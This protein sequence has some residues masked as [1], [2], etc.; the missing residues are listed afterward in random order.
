M[1]YLKLFFVI[2]LA[3]I[4]ANLLAANIQS[5]I[6]RYRTRELRELEREKLQLEI[7][8]KKRTLNK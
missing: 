4:V 5:E 8:Y 6:E 2:I 7:E 3:V 1:N